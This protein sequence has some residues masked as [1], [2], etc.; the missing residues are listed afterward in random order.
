MQPD[1][2]VARMSPVAQV[3]LLRVYANPGAWRVLPGAVRKKLRHESLVVQNR[4]D[5]WELTELGHAVRKYL[6]FKETKND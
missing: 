1:E 5:E 6:T 3:A 2:I 4:S